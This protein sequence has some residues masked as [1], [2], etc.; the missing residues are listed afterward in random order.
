MKSRA[1]GFSKEIVSELFKLIESSFNRTLNG[2]RLY[3]YNVYE[4]ALTTFYKK[5]ER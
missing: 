1:E 5:P 4:T 2:A 3:V